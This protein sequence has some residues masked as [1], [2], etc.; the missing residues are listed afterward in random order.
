M[1]CYCAVLQVT[2]VAVNTDLDIVVSGSKVCAVLGCCGGIYV[3]A[4]LYAVFFVLM[5]CLLA[6]LVVV[7]PL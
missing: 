7:I 1:I 6:C 2:C 4:F 3:L 5:F